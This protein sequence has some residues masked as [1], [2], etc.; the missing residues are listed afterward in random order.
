MPETYD[1][2]AR[3]CR[4]SVEVAWVNEERERLGG[5][6]RRDELYAWYPSEFGSIALSVWEMVGQ[7]TRQLNTAWAIFSSMSTVMEAPGF[8]DRNM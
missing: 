7:P 8:W 6:A 3:D 2:D 1:S 5:L 4:I